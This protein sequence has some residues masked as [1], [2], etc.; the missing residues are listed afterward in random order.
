MKP[1]SLL[2][3]Q[4]LDVG[5]EIEI[6]HSADNLGAHLSLDGDPEIGPGDRVR[7]YGP[8]IEVAFGDHFKVR[9]RAVIERATPLLRLWTKLTGHFEMAELYDVSFTPGRV[10]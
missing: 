3:R 10:S 8:P 4:T 7:V 9:R 1:S 5:C 2:W 6:D